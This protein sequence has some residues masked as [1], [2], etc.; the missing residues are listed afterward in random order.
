VSALPYLGRV[1]PHDL[2]HVRHGKVHDVVSP[3]QLQDHVRP[4]QVVA[5]EQTRGEA[6]V[7]LVLEEPRNQV[8]GDVIVPR[9]G[10]VQHR[11]L[12]S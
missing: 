3:R 10:R 7:V 2:Y 1:F 11:I 6:L 9:L 8:L 5:L 12:L 4:Q